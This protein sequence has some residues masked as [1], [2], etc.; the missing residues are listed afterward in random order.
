MSR[1]SSKSFVWHSIYESIEHPQ[2]GIFSERVGVVVLGV[3]VLA[4]V[5]SFFL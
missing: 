2:G 5:V 1:K 3:I 4:I